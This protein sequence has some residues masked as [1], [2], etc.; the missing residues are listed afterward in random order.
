MA[1]G[2]IT[3]PVDLISLALRCAGVLGVGQTGDASDTM[4]AFV[5]LNLMLSQWA[6]SRWLVYTLVDNSVESTGAQF[7]TVGPGGDFDIARIDRLESAYARLRQGSPTN[8]FDF[9]LVLID[10]REVYSDICL[11]SLTTFPTSV[12]LDSDY[13]SGKAYFWP[14]PAA[15]QF[16]LHIITKK[17][18]NQFATLTDSI[19][20]PP[21]YLDA[22]LWNLAVR[23]RPLYQLPPDPTAVALAK[24]ALNN[25]RQA[26]AQV[27]ELRMPGSVMN[28]R[29]GYDVTLGNLNGLP[30]SV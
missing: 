25:L 15:G 29:S 24:G 12:Y 17:E 27:A 11:K 4:D 10:S 20:M 8:P 18:I 14:V 21:E 13:P 1:S 2:T 6:R 23:L 22:L 7:Y 3:T 16:D 9:P 28:V 26:N 5:L 30:W 19:D